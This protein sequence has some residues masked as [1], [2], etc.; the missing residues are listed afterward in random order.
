M[1]RYTVILTPEPEAGG[2]SV[3]VPAL[4]GCYSQGESFEEALANARE[5]IGLHLGGMVRDGE[6]VPSDV[7]PIITAIDAEPL[8]VQ[9][10]STERLAAIDSAPPW[11]GRSW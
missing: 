10:P 9:E 8:D 11:D 1:S 4:P 5:A 7:A 2:Y 6:Q 3:S